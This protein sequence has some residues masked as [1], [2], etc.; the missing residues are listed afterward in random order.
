[1]EGC[2]GRLLVCLMDLDLDLASG[3]R[4]ASVASGAADVGAGC[5]G[6][7][8]SWKRGRG[9]EMHAGVQREGG[10]PGRVER[11]HLKHR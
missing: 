3:V 10:V 1:M 7:G 2:D 6:D 5:R 4:T 9:S 11:C 8:G